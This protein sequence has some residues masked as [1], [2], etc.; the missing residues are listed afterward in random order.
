MQDF[1][2]E[3][4]Q[5]LI[6]VTSSQYSL[7]GEISL[8]LG[9]NADLLEAGH[10]LTLNSFDFKSLV[11]DALANLATFLEVVKAVLLGALT[12]HGDLLPRK[13][14]RSNFGVKN[15]QITVTST[16]YLIVWA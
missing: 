7:L 2:Y 16:T 5:P 12:I 14:A 13:Q 6:I 15:I 4:A 9:C 1:S 11:F 8:V 10:F 3:L